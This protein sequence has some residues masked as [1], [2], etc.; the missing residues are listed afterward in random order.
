MK[1]LACVDFSFF[2]FLE[3]GDEEVYVPRLEDWNFKRWKYRE[4]IRKYVLRFN[5]K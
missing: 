3:K 5:E 2:F 4:G 1:F